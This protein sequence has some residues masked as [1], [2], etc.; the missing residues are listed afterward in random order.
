MTHHT[1]QNLRDM[2]REL[3]EVFEQMLPAEDECVQRHSNARLETQ[4]LA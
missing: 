4:W 1:P 3:Q 2:V